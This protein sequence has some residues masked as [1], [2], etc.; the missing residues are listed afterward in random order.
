MALLPQNMRTL[1]ELDDE[2]D[3]FELVKV[4]HALRAVVAAV[5]AARAVAWAALAIE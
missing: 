4:C 5:C 1:E 2:L 3:G